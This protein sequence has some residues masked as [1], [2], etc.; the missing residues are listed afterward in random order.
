[1]NLV[2]KIELQEYAQRGVKMEF[3]Q[4]KLLELK[5]TNIEQIEQSYNIHNF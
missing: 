5:K 3:I 4:E 2:F 1:V